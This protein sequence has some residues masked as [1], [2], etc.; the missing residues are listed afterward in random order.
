VS[1]IGSGK[2]RGKDGH[3]ALAAMVVVVESLR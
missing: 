3:R 1:A 2:W